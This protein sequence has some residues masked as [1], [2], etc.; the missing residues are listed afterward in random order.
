MLDGMLPVRPRNEND[1]K[2][3]V[4][5]FPKLAGMVPVERNWI[6]DAEFLRVPDGEM[7]AVSRGEVPWHTEAHM[8]VILPFEAQET[9]E[10][11]Q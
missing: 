3:K 5:K 8:L 11:V 7:S 9:P 10:K 4:I 6:Q 1:N 2:V